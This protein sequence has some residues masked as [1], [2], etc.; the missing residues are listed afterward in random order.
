MI[1]AEDG[2]GRPTL[3]TPSIV[4]VIQAVRL[5]IKLQTADRDAML[6]AMRVAAEKRIEAILGHSRRRHYGHAAMLAAACVAL[7]PT[8]R[9]QELITWSTVLQQNY[10]RRSAF[11]QELWRALEGFGVRGVPELPGRRA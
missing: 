2:A 11:R 3:E 10:S 1:S 7:A 8:G 9:R 4:A 6:D 5:S